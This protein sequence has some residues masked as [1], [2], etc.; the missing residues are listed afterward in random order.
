MKTLKICVSLNS[1]IVSTPFNAREQP[2]IQQLCEDFVDW[3][4]FSTTNSSISKC[5]IVIHFWELLDTMNCYCIY[6]YNVYLFKIIY[7]IYLFLNIICVYQSFNSNKT[8]HPP[9]ICIKLTT[10]K[11]VRVIPFR[12]LTN[13]FIH[14]CN[15]PCFKV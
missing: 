13:F 7:Y 11:I 15:V 8:K 10:F 2:E 9:S 5:L 14:K 6:S 1:I 4:I 12:L 3:R